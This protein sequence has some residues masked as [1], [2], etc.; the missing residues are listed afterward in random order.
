MKW[1]AIGD[2]NNNAPIQDGIGAKILKFG[3][4]LV[5]Y[6]EVDCVN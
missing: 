3:D 4:N 2:M 6:W 1:K 5:G